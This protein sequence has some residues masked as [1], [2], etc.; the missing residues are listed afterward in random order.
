MPKIDKQG[1]NLDA[2]RVFMIAQNVLA[3][4][5][6][7]PKTMTKDQVQAH[8]YSD[9]GPAGTSAGWQVEEVE[10]EDERQVSPGRCDD[11][12]NRQHWK[13]CC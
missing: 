6:C 3:G 9:V 8:V 11:D 4:W 2:N 1:N 5:V 7:A 13:V 12:C 10:S